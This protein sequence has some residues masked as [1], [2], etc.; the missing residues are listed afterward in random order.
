MIETRTTPLGIRL[1]N[2][3]NIERGDPWQG[4]A[5]EQ[6]HERFCA[7]VSPV[8]GIRAIARTLITYQDKYGIRTIR[9]AISRWAPSHD[10]N[11]TAAYIASVS[12]RT[13]FGPDLPLD[14]HRYGDV[15]P[16]AEAIIRHENGRG[17]LATVNSWYDD[18]TVHK[19]MLLAG[20]EPEQR[21]VGPVPVSRETIGATATGGVGIAQVA[22]ALPAVVESIQQAEAHLTSGSSVRLAIGLVLIALAVV[23]ATGQVRRFK[24]GTL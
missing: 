15:R 4:L 19:A 12:Q 17:P 2:P 13:G 10:R 22:D 8:Y 14:M 5:P 24:A 9:G 21:H 20:V 16:L 3:G 18:E 1:A 23:I 11:D 6:P 7:F